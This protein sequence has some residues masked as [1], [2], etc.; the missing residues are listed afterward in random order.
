MALVGGAVSWPYAAR[1]QQLGKPRRIAL[2]HSGIPADKLTQQDGPFWIRRLYA[3]LRVL[4]Y[5]EGANLTVER[6]SAEGHSDRF[7]S[8]AAA[9]VSS[10]P[11]VIVSNFNALV[12]AIMKATATIPIVGL[13]GDPVSDGLISNL[14]RPGGNL[15][16]ASIGAGGA[17]GSKRLQIL[18]EAV[19]AASNVASLFGSSAEQQ[20]SGIT[21]GVKIITDVNEAQLRATFAEMAEQKVDAVLVSETGS[22][23]AQRTL[24]VALAAQHRLPAMYPYRDYAEAGGLMAYAPDLAELAKR[25]ASDV[26][27][28]F[29][30]V[31]AG[32][33]PFFLPTK[34]DLVINLKTAKQLGL[35]LPPAVLDFASEVIE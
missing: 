17:M 23:L 24:I 29:K 2:I 26:A 22:F 9:V 30:G 8:V 6:Y 7:A 3:E 5:A 31:N 35:T 33:I 1:A 25:L 34:F 28:I 4:G 10:N 32:D 21:P 27:Q 15:T 11:D 19:P 14:A 13:T 18:R 20:R 16:G 12:K